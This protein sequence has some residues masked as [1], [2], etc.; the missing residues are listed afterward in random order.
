MEGT[1]K[2]SIFVENLLKM[3][4]ENA[5]V[6]LREIT[7]ERMKKEGWT[8][9]ELAFLMGTTKQVVSNWLNG[10]QNLRYE[11]VERLLQVLQYKP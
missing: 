2:H 10:R 11:L 3:I 4:D 1:D 6:N 5:K 9:A 7:K 8:Q